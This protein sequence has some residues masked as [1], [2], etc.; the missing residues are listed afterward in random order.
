MKNEKRRHSRVVPI[1]VFLSFSFSVFRFS[2]AQTTQ[3]APD[4]PSIQRWLEELTHTEPAA[5]ERARMQLM[6]LSREGLGEL[7]EAV[8][9][10]RPLSPAQAAVLH[11]VVIHVYV[12]GSERAPSVFMRP[13]GFLGVLLEPV[14][15]GYGI[16]VAPPAPQPGDENPVDFGQFHASGGVLIRETWPGFA[17]FRFLR[18][19]DV[20]L[21]T[22]GDQPTRSPTVPEL[23]SAVQTTTPGAI[24][25]LQVLRQGRIVEVPVRVSMRPPWAESETRTR[26]MLSRRIRAAEIYWHFAFAPLLLQDD[27]ML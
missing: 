13:T 16:G 20:V 17:G 21:G 15:S 8:D 2:F 23:R 10:M 27:G 1:L 3:P 24:L 18:V 25:D 9:R 19:G 7:R 5:R 14:L 12:A 22:G 4:S 26:Q 11:D 6:G